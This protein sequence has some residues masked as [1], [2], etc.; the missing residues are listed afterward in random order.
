MFRSQIQI[1]KERQET[2]SGVGYI[3]NVGQTVGPSSS[4][5]VVFVGTNRARREKRRIGG[6][7]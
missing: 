7:L 2:L 3:E 4:F 5:I 6:A 1:G